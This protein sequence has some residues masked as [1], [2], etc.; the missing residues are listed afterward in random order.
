MSEADSFLARTAEGRTAARRRR[1][2][3]IRVMIEVE[4]EEVAAEGAWSSSR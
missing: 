3:R 2:E 1:E 4:R